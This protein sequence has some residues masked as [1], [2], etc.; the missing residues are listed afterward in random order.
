MPALIARRL[1]ILHSRRMD[2]TRTRLFCDRTRGLP[3]WV[4]GRG[5]LICGAQIS[6]RLHHTPHSS[7][8]REFNAGARRDNYGAKLSL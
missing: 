5:M 2:T 7:A 4:R 1:Y 8:V 6:R 3:D